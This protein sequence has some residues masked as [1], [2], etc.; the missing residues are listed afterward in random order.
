MLAV[1]EHLNLVVTIPVDMEIYVVL[2]AAKTASQ[3][4]PG[5]TVLSRSIGHAPEHEA[6]A[7][8]VGDNFAFRQA[9]FSDHQL[10]RLGKRHRRH[11]PGPTCGS[12]AERGRH[13]KGTV[14]P[15]SDLR[16]L[17]ACVPP[18]RFCFWPLPRVVMAA[19]ASPRE[20]SVKNCLRDFD[21]V[22]SII[23]LSRSLDAVDGSRWHPDRPSPRRAV[24]F[25]R[26]GAPGT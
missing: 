20:A 12:S 14:Q 22:S 1:T 9:Y 8:A 10:L 18:A 11:P 21:M 26:R 17:L 16:A 25:H 6:L 19:L 23:R 5:P 3:L 24:C 2:R 7:P 4:K 13:P 15:A